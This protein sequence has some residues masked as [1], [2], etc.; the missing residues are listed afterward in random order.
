MDHQFSS[1]LGIISTETSWDFY[2]TFS[3]SRYGLV[4]SH[5][6]QGKLTVY[7][8]TM[9]RIASV[10]W[11]FVGSSPMEMIKD[12]W[13]WMLKPKSRTIP[14][15]P[16]ILE[17]LGDDV[18]LVRNSGWLIY[19]WSGLDSPLLNTYKVSSECLGNA[20]TVHGSLAP[21]RSQWI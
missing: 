9:P 15:K 11:K 20:P 13:I 8:T 16:V 14:S 6:W 21:F 18:N 10:M 1:F 4:T 17:E 19:L 3:I 12:D 7:T 5:T 2:D